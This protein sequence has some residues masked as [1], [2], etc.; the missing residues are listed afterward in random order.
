MSPRSVMG[1]HP[2]RRS[3]RTRS[4]SASPA[5]KGPD[6]AAPGDIRAFDIRTGREVWRFRTV[7]GPAEFG[8]E[9][10]EGASWK[11]RGGANAW[12][13]FSVDVERGLVFAGLGS[14]AFDFYGGDRRG[15][16]S[17]RQLHDRSRC[18]T[19][20]RVWHFQTLHHD[21]WD[22]D[23]PVYP[24]LVTVTARRQANRR[25]RPSHEN[26]LRLPV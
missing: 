25:R 13:G 23:L 21:L 4:S 19:G 7:P 9:T 12:G 20:A 14:A 15:D 24:N 11:D 10:W 8:H 6:I 5:A 3:G 16:K 18:K 26:G 2:P 22:H 17:V 1:R